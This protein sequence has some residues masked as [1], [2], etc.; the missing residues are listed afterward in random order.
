MVGGL[1]MVGGSTRG[2]KGDVG[3]G[4]G[5][6]FVL[7]RKTPRIYNRLTFV[8]T[9]AQVCM[10]AYRREIQTP[11]L[12]SSLHKTATTA[13]SSPGNPHQAA[14]AAASRCQLRARRLYEIRCGRSAAAPRR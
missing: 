3:G 13:R 11:L 5:R 12:S 4:G 2:C 1:P 9:I 14:S 10:P 6:R 7:G 8:N